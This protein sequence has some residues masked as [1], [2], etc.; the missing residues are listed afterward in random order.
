MIEKQ[1]PQVIKTANRFSATVRLDHTCSSLSDTTYTPSG[2]AISAG[3]TWSV[4]GGAFLCFFAQAYIESDILEEVE[5]LLSSFRSSISSCL[6]PIPLPLGLI[7]IPLLVCLIPIPLSMS[8]SHAALSMSDSHT[9]LSRHVYMCMTTAG[10]W[11]VENYRS[12]W[13]SQ[14]SLSPS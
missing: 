8:D 4:L 13:V 5:M 3:C 12:I 11:S 10:C 9:S 1:P 7:S 14:R 6:I 2:N